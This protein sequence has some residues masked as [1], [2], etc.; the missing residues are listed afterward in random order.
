MIVKLGMLYRIDVDQI[1]ID[2]YCEALEHYGSNE[3]SQALARIVK[4]DQWFP[5]IAY[6]LKELR[7]LFPDNEYKAL[8]PPPLTIEDIA[9]RI[10]AMGFARMIPTLT[11]ELCPPIDWTVEFDKYKKARWTDAL[12]KAAKEMADGRRT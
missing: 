10:V 7:D 11:K 5:T 1:V 2:G 6:T 3:I 12:K 9:G 8:P 4:R